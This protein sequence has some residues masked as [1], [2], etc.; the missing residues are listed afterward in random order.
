ML[1]KYISFAFLA[2]FV[3]TGVFH[4][5][6]YLL[7]GVLNSDSFS[8]FSFHGDDIRFWV[9]YG[10]GLFV[11]F[12]FKYFLDK[13]FVF[14]DKTESQEKEVKKVLLYAL[15]SVF[16][17]FILTLIVGGFKAYISRE[18]AKDA[19]LVI[20]LLIGYT[21][22][23]FLDRKFVFNQKLIQENPVNLSVKKDEIKARY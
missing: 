17:T 2:T 23:F 13:K 6:D 8:L 19:G 12:V 14:A 11:G 9:S 16:T 20:G 21:I 10:L 1:V 15:M 4:L 3:N 18:R 7:Q 22:K 5:T